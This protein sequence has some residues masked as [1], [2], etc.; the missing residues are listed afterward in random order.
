M[1]HITE[2]QLVAY[3]LDDVEVDARAAVESHVELCEACRSGDRRVARDARTAGLPVP[4][5][6]DD[7][8]AEVW[9]RL[10]P[11]L[12]TSRARST[13]GTARRQ[14]HAGTS[15]R[16][17]SVLAGRRGALL[18]GA[19]WLGRY[20]A[21]AGR[22][23]TTTDGGVVARFASVS[24]WPPSANTSIGRNGRWWNWSTPR[25]WSRGHLGRAGLGARPARSQPPLSSSHRRCRDACAVAGPRGP[26]ARAAGDC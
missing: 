12:A 4:E 26:R 20:D 9:A 7:Y 8:G 25:R 24:C 23:P 1:T 5:R 21:A 14:R 6:G 10:E 2:E 15:A 16:Q 13:R 22:S 3:A 11:R 18:A 17:P 19:Y